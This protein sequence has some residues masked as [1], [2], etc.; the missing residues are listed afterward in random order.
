MY[1]LVYVLVYVLG[2]RVR[3]AC[4]VYMLGCVWVCFVRVSG[5]LKVR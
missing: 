1:V 5:P 2:V 4:V 3:D